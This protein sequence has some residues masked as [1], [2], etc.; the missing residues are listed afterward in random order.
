MTIPD[1]KPKWDEKHRRG[2]HEMLRDIP[3]PFS[4]IA[5][6]YFGRGARIVELGTGVGRD[7][8][9][10]AKLGHLVIATDASEVVIEKNKHHPAHANVQYGVLDVRRAFPF[11]PASF[12]AVYSNLALHYFDDDQTREVISKVRN[13][14]KS[15]GIFALACKSSD[16]F[17]GARSTIDENNILVTDDERALHLFSIP[18]MLDVLAG[19]FDIMYIDEVPDV[20]EG[21]ESTIVRCVALALGKS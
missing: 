19:Q 8:N 5:E 17:K 4:A 20:Y 6:P 2:D 12:D 1:Q 10:F 14:I 9:Y 11:A 18:Y 21:N 3:S 16:S 13:V 15:W 7:A